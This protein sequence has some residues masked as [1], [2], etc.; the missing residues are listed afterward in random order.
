MKKTT[1]TYTKK[2]FAIVLCLILSNIA[3]AQNVT[4]SG[5]LAGNGSYPDLNSAFA[6]INGGAQTSATITV[7]LVGNTTETV[8]AVLNSGAW[9]SLMIQPSGGSAR[10]ITGAIAGHL[11]DLNGADNVMI[12]GLNTGGNAL[13][14]SNT[15]TGTVSTIRFINTAINNTITN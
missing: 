9:T 5:A 4:V 12:N 6:A 8:S 15:N 13:S 2:F 1:L 14:I 10:N 3:F 7:D 11:I